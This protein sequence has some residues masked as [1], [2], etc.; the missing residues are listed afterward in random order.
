MK[1]ASLLSLLL[2]ACGA[3]APAAAPSD[4]S[5]AEAA[6]VSPAAARDAGG[7]DLPVT[8]EPPTPAAAAPTA[9]ACPRPALPVVLVA[10]VAVASLAK[11]GAVDGDANVAPKQ[12]FRGSV[13]QHATLA[14]GQHQ[15][16]RVPANALVAEGAKAGTIEVYV[17]KT[18]GFAGH[19]PE[20]MSVE[21]V[22]RNLGLATT[23]DGTTF[24]LA[25]YGEF[26]TRIE[27]AATMQL[28]VR[29]PKAFPV[30][31]SDGL[32]GDDSEAARWPADEASQ[33]GADA[34]RVGYW[35]APVNPR[36]G[37]SRVKL[38]DDA[39]RVASH[40]GAYPKLAPPCAR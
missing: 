18:L 23:D 28:F 39:Q 14:V 3:P 16:L 22:R 12:A 20:T 38:V 24:V 11:P 32:S 1:L 36:K 17:A 6:P 4:S 37:W 30:H 21:S 5:S 27:G 8:I 26:D 33:R 15:A 2:L 13:Y 31:V 25:S 10:D 40:A 29:V 19:P 35:Y 9:G 34:G 7:A